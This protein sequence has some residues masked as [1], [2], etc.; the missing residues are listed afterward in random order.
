VINQWKLPAVKFSRRDGKKYLHSTQRAALCRFQRIGEDSVRFH[1]Q[2]N[3]GKVDIHV[4]TIA[5]DSHAPAMAAGSAI[6]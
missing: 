2:L 1:T 5:S 3:S 4:Y 6:D